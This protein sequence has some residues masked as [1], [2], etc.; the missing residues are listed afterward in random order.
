[1]LVAAGADIESECPISTTLVG[2]KRPLHLAIDESS[3][4]FLNIL[5]D[6]GA[7]FLDGFECGLSYKVDALQYAITKNCSEEILR[8]LVLRGADVNNY[9]STPF[10]PLHLAVMSNGYGIIGPLCQLGANL[11]ARTLD[12]QNAIPFLLA[13]G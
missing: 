3:A 2:S 12:G 9:K 13:L 5:L 10:S 6:A 8:S 1:M 11:E 7:N 4:L